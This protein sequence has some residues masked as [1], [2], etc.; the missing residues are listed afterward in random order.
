MK[1]DDE[2]HAL[3]EAVGL[4]P[5]KPFSHRPGALDYFPVPEAAIEDPVALIEWVNQGVAAGLRALEK[6]RPRT[7]PT[8]LQ[9]CY[10]RS[11]ATSGP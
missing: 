10:H 3:F 11:S 6:K 4:A 7:A 5:L 9:A 8:S 2:N 1:A